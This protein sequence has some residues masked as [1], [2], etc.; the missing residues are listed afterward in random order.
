M[1]DTVYQQRLQQIQQMPPGPE[2]EAALAALSRDYAGLQ[3]AAQTRQQRGYEMAS[4][5]GPQGTEL[6][7]K[8]STYVAAN[9]LEHL[10]SGLRRYKGY[11][12]MRE[13]DEELGTLSEDKQKT[14]ADLLRSAL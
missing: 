1:S 11:K 14:L 13:A 5:K 12:D 6:G 2:R 10:A 7:G 9:P 8:Y 4:E 3:A